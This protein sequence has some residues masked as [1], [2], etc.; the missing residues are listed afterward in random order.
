M[1]IGSSRVPYFPALHFSDP[2]SGKILSAGQMLLQLKGGGVLK[3]HHQSSNHDRGPFLCASH[4]IFD[5]NVEAKR[6]FGPSELFILLIIPTHKHTHTHAHTNTSTRTHEYVNTH[7][8]TTWPTEQTSSRLS[9]LIHIYF[10][11][12]IHYLFSISSFH[13]V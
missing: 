7:T 1:Q 5:P 3:R 9:L 12:G 6:D 2:Q 8:L 10:V 13:S 11:D 4:G